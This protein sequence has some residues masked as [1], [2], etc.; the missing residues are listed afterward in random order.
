MVIN[1]WDSIKNVTCDS[2]NRC[3]AFSNGT[4]V[5]NYF[6]MKKVTSL[7]VYLFINYII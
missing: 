1:Q 5:I 2:V 4:D 7:Q 3:C 6:S